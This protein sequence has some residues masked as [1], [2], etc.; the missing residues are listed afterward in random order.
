M[1]RYTHLSLEE[2]TLISHYHDNG[3]SMVQIPKNLGRDKSCISRELK[4]N[5]NEKDYK[6]Q[7]AMNRYLT[8]CHRESIQ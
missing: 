5:R 6:P 2:R 8:R 7:T 1:K 3:I 4:R